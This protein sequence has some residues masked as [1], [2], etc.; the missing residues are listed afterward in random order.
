MELFI[1]SI[2]LKKKFSRAVTLLYL[3][4]LVYYYNIIYCVPLFIYYKAR[5]Q[6]SLLSFLY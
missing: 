4:V 2:T 3:L 5:Y 1:C 6:I